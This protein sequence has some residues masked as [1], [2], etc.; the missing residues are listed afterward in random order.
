MR[1]RR[2]AAL[3]L[4][5]VHQVAIAIW[6][7]S[8][9]G[10]GAVAAPAVF[11]TAKAAGDTVWGTPLYNFAGL[12]AE[13]IFARLNVVVLVAG[14]VAL[15][16]GLVYP[17]LAGLC[18]RRGAV[19]SALTAVALVVEAALMFGMFD[20]MVA[21]RIAGEMAEFDQLHR[22]Y[23]LGFQFQAVLLLVII[24]ITGWMH[25]AH[26]ATATTASDETERPSADRA[27]VQTAS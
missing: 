24:G 14:C 6:M 15:L 21:L 17:R 22:L 11:K 10:A 19:R 25:L 18:S 27:A 12:A 20:R 13:G 5:W 8:I 9:F 23:S 1:S 7:G 2:F 26:A 3:L 16:A 4:S